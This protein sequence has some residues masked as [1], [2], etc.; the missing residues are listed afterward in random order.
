MKRTGTLALAAAAAA[1]LGG[2]VIV[3]A[4]VRDYGWDDDGYGY[5]YGAEISERSQEITILVHSNGC[6]D[7]GDFRVNI[8]RRGEHRFDVGFRRMEKDYCKALVPEGAR[9]TWSYAELGLPRDAR[10]MIVNQVGR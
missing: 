5:L 9:M 2:C 1:M 3:D 10:V 8:D 7:K 4:D 6:T